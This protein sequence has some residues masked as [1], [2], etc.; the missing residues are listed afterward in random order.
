[1]IKAFVCDQNQ[2]VLDF[3][4]FSDFYNMFRIWDLG[5]R[6]AVYANIHDS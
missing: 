4:Y 3:G 2:R 6:H 5:I 1:M